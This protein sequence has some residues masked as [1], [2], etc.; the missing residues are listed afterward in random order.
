MKASTLETWIWTLI[1][2]GLGGV[3]VG[4]FMMSF[5][6]VLGHALVWCGVAVAALGAVGIWARSRMRADDVAKGPPKP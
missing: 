5:D 6:E 4:A 1:Y 2:G 3:M